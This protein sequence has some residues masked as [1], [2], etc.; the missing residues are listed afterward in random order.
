MRCTVTWVMTP[1]PDVLV[2]PLTEPRFRELVARLY[3]GSKL[4]AVEP[5]SPDSGATSA[6]TSKVAGYGEPVRLVIDDGD[7]RAHRHR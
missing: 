4:V 3:P 2:G 1:K 6:S 7:R 5:L